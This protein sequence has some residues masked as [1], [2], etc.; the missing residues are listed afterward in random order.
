MNELIEK[1][2]SMTQKINI[3]E[4]T[5]L[6]RLDYNK[7]LDE[8]TRG[9]KG[10]FMTPSNV[11]YLLASMFNNLDG[12]QRILDAGAG[13]GSL[14]ATLIERAINEFCP[15]KIETEFWE[16]EPILIDGLAKTIDLLKDSCL[17]K[18][19]DYVYNIHNENFILN[20]E[21]IIRKADTLFDKAILNPPYLKISAKS[22]ERKVLKN[23]GVETGNLYSC[24]ISIALMLLKDGGELVAITPRSFCNGPYFN[25]FRKFILERNNLNRITIF[26]SRKKTFKEDKVLQENII[27]HIIKGEKQGNVKI[28]T[29][30]SLA[31]ETPNTRICNFEDIVPLGNPEKF[32]HIIT[33]D[34]QAK[35]AKKI[36][37]M[38]CSLQDLNVE[39]STGRVVDFRTRDNLTNA[40]TE[41]E[42][43]TPLIYPHNFIENIISWPIQHKKKN[44]AL[45]VN[46]ETKSLLV[47][48]GHYVL[49][50][51][52]TAKEEKKRVVAA[53]YAPT[54][55]HKMVG[56]EN[57]TN[58]IHCKNSG[59]DEYLAKGLTVYLNSSLVDAYFRQFNGHTQVNSADLRIMRY[60][61]LNTL[62]TIG[63]NIKSFSQEEID[64]YINIL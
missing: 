23:L 19:I 31:D 21:E 26:E 40:L 13:V 39:I 3:S 30:S 44:N 63:K 6:I 27:F 29:L 37:Q 18:N 55:D 32:I 52:L 58:Y 33:N 25:D 49:I 16:I 35:I 24:F 4:R 56:F 22:K 7:K 64:S 9:E 50:K 15:K 54:S 38:P 8:K 61:D 57:K 48:N 45:K 20:S 14:T 12:V 5:D 2:E 62:K 28:S 53:Y 34:L 41:K 1:K 11:A 51:R 59:L 10:Q 60:P 43:F 47:P 42:I 46:E 36:G 17:K